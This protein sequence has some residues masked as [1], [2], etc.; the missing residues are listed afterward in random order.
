MAPRRKKSIFIRWKD[1]TPA[2]KQRYIRV[3]AARALVVL[4][5]IL[6]LVLLIKG[7]SALAGKLFGTKEEPEQITVTE[8]QEV[9]ESTESAE[10][11]TVQTLT[12]T[13]AGDCVLANKDGAKKSG[14]FEKYYE[15]YGEEYFFDSIRGVLESDDITLVNL[16]CT[17]TTQT[18]A[19]GD[20]DTYRSDP[21]H[22]GILTSSSINAVTLG[23]D[24]T[25][26]YGTQGLEDTQAALTE[27]GITWAGGSDYGYYQTQTGLVVGIVS[28]DL[29]ADADAG[30]Q[31]LLSG[32]ETLS[33]QANL[34]VACCH[35]GKT[36]SYRTKNSQK[37]LAHK[38]VDAGADLVI[39]THPQ[40]LQGVELYQGKVIC[41]SL[42]NFCF[43]GSKDVEDMNT[44]MFRQTFTFVNGEVTDDLDAMI[45][46]ARISS[47]T[48]MND[49]QT[50]VA[51]TH[52]EEIIEAVNGYC[53]DLGNVSFDN[54]GYLLVD[55]QSTTE[56]SSEE[57]TGEE[58]AAE[59]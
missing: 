6:L 45:I 9:S 21:S 56:R 3:Y 37:E 38:L 42:G 36:E 16:E 50:A 32:I 8:T 43:G 20:G 33:S 12:I 10:Q 23:N 24:H 27:A 39:G 2:K 44:M 29:T 1:F 5:G 13:A 30:E 46:P 15:D 14:S 26:D 22:V 11:T 7:I 18:T 41:Y 49:Y 57:A 31:Q 4:A 35:W 51:V 47:Q 59:N 52:R 25:M 54:L 28:A 17:F 19:E 58:A 40:V 48:G 55:G 53:Q 34:V